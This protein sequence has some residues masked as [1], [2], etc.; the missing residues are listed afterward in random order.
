MATRQK[1]Y[2]QPTEYKC[3]YCLKA[4]VPNV[5]QSCKLCASKTCEQCGKP[6]SS[7]FRK[8]T[9]CVS[10]KKHL[11]LYGKTDE[12]VH[13]TVAFQITYNVT[14]NEHNG[15]CSGAE[16]IDVDRT[17][18]V[19]DV[20]ALIGIPSN[21]LTPGRII[22]KEEFSENNPKYWQYYMTLGCSHGSGY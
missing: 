11:I 3:R 13:D 6:Y 10:K 19:D 4:K 9:N 12:P 2:S 18:I 1:K 21:L 15:Y 16:S 7:F 20:P 17:E 8:C 14:G 5:S 22:N